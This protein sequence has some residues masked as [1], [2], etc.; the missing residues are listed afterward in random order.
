MRVRA[1]DAQCLLLAAFPALGC[2]GKIRGR[3]YK[4]R[5]P[6]LVL[7]DDI[8]GRESV[9]S[10]LVRT[11]LWNQWFLKEVMKAGQLDGSTDFIVLGTILHEDS[12][13][14]KLLDHSTSPDWE[15]EK[16]Q[17]VISFASNQEL[18]EHWES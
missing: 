18:W 7:I 14:S 4:G 3:K 6:E 8:E 5:R 9:E 11:K 13:L 10:D 17:A 16:F 2:G 15:K 1:G 12:I